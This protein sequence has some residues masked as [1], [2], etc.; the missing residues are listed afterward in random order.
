MLF[1]KLLLEM[2]PAKDHQDLSYPQ[3]RSSVSSNMQILSVNKKVSLIELNLALLIP[4][5][6]AGAD[7]K[8]NAEMHLHSLTHSR[9]WVNHIAISNNAEQQEMDNAKQKSTIKSISK[10]KKCRD[11]AVDGEN[12]FTC[13]SEMEEIWLNMLA[14]IHSTYLKDFLHH[15]VKLASLTITSGKEFLLQTSI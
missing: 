6:S 1:Y 12:H 5:I 7:Y 9:W 11:K 8:S 3:V 10:Q 15:R 4:V 13:I 2:L 14:R